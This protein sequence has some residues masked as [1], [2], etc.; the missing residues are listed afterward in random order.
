MTTTKTNNEQQ[1]TDKEQMIWGF[2]AGIYTGGAGHPVFCG[3]CGGL[4]HE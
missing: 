3:E 1:R 2:A 4:L